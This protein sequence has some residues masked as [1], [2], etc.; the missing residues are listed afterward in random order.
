MSS[1]RDT[2]DRGGS[3]GTE[4]DTEGKRRRVSREKD[5]GAGSVSSVE[6]TEG[7]AGSASTEKGVGVGVGQFYE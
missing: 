4:E 1:G 7:R 5:V 6:N 2:E 3:V